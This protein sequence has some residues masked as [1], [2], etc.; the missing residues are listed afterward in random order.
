MTTTKVAVIGANGRAGSAIVHDLASRGKYE[1]YAVARNPSKV[2]YDLPNVKVVQGEPAKPEA[3]FPEIKGIDVLVSAIYFD[4]TP[5]ELIK[6]A[7]EAGAKRIVIVGG[8]GCLQVAEGG[9]RLIDTPQFPDEFR[10]IAE[11][12][13]KFFDNLST[14][15][16]YDWTFFCPPLDIFVGPKVGKFRLGGDVLMMDESGTSRIS[17]DDFATALVDEIDNGAYIKKRG[18]VAY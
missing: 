17:Y 16:D 4:I 7:K 9:P 13:V 14:V 11:P 8:A 1:V 6:I 10:W 18:T 15:T 2:T 12:G 5:A 3:L